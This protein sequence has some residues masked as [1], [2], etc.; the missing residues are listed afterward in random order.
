MF[1][2]VSSPAFRESG[3]KPLMQLISWVVLT[4]FLSAEFS[5]QQLQHKP[6]TGQN[7]RVQCI[8]EILADIKYTASCTFL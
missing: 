3:P 1:S 2:S 7:N 6:A 5:M 8:Q 4:V